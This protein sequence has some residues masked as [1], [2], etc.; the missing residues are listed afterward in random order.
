MA[1]TAVSMLPWPEM[2]TTGRSGCAFLTILSTSSPSSRLPCSQMSRITRCGRRSSTAFKASS[3]S[4]ASRVR[5]PSSCRMPATISR[6][7]AS[8]A[9]IRMSDAICRSFAH[10]QSCAARCGGGGRCRLPAR[11]L[12]LGGAAHRQRDADQGAVAAPGPGRGVLQRQGAAV[13]L[14]TLLHDGEAEASALPLTLGRHIGLEQP[15]AVLLGQARAVVDYLDVDAVAVAAHDRLDAPAP[16][17]FLLRALRILLDRLLGVLHEVVDRLRDQPAVA[18][19]DDRLVAQPLVEG[20]VAVAHLPVEH[21]G[22]HDVADVVILHLRL[23]HAREGGELVDHACHVPDLPDDRVGALLE[24]V[25]VF[26]DHPAVLALD[27]LGRELYRGQRVLDL[28]GDAARHVGPRRGAL[29]RDELGDVVEGDHRAVVLLPLLLV[30][31][32]HHE[33]AL[34]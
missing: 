14:D 21:G 5:W 33:V 25:P 9:T 23:G 2:M 13:L 17:L 19:D 18:G 11:R 24:H 4:R 10:W 28:V 7:S 15:H 20:D 1:V 22:A 12:A 32:A 27:A 30:R 6:M 16:T 29:C 8:S 26:R 3:E 31:H 34:L